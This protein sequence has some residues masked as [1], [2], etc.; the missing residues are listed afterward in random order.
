[1]QMHSTHWWLRAAGALAAGVSG[2]LLSFQSAADEP[3]RALRPFLTKGDTWTY[4][5]VRTHP[6]GKRAVDI[7]TV[8]VT[9]VNPATDSIQADIDMRPEGMPANAEPDRTAVWTLEW[10]ARLLSR[11]GIGLGTILH[12][13]GAAFRFPMKVGDVFETAYEMT[14]STKSGPGDVFR[15]RRTSRVARW[16]EIALPAGKLNTIV[17]ESTGTV[18]KV[19][20]NQSWPMNVTFWYAPEVRRQVKS[21][22]RGWPIDADVELLS[23]KLAEVQ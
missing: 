14:L 19:G 23:Y 7:E 15:V 21:R 10:N 8:T 1:M 20:S 13:H 16:E 22:Q 11:P 6:D 12:P 5:H 2:I 3:A 9:T 18:E 4:R 17:I